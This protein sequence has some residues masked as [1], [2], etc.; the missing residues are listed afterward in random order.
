M[1]PETA[2]KVKSLVAD[3]AIVLGPKPITSPSLCDYPN[4]DSH[5]S[6]IGN[7]VWGDSHRRR[8]FMNMISAKEKSIGISP[9]PMFWLPRGSSPIFKPRPSSPD[10]SDTIHRRDG[11]S[12]IYFL[13]N[14]DDH[15]IDLHAVVSRYRENSGNLVSRRWT[16]GNGRH[17]GSRMPAEPKCLSLWSPTNPSSSSSNIRRLRRDHVVTW[18]TDVSD[19]SS[20]VPAWSA[21]SPRRRIASPI[22]D[23]R[24]HINCNM[25]PAD[26]KRSVVSPFRSSIDLSGKWNVHF[27]QKMGRPRLHHPRP[28]AILD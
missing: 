6:A 13:A 18:A 4:C 12:D 25:P 9:S 11:D 16:S 2:A 20:S 23:S 21:F 24:R 19:E 27:P 3:G 10:K 15:E 1:L 26:P 22:R 17:H 8:A 28:F 14:F 5:V 7:E